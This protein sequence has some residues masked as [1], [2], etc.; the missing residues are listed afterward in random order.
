MAPTPTQRLADLL[1]P[2]GLEEFV[3][4]RRADGKAW[5]LVARDVYEATDRQIDVTY[6]SLRSWYPDDQKASA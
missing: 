2:G 4:S 5:R 1:I 3:R 6:E